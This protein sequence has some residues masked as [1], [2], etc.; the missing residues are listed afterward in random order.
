MERRERIDRLVQERIDQA[1]Q[2]DL[3]R[4]LINLFYYNAVDAWPIWI[5]RSR[6]DLP[7]DV[8]V[9]EALDKSTDCSVA[10]VR[11][12]GTDFTFAKRKVGEDPLESYEYS[13]WSYEISAFDQLVFAVEVSDHWEGGKPRLKAITAYI[14][15]PWEE[16]F[17]LLKA[18][19]DERTREAAAKT[20]DEERKE[21]RR[22]E[23]ERLARFGLEDP[24]GSSGT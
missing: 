18:Q 10:L 19:C 14:P 23:Q 2:R 3:P 4:L 1:M 15:G 5:S 24:D 13:Y 16:H 6:S 8:E 11:F 12:K 21:N 9:A 17:L 7:R 22:K 20:T